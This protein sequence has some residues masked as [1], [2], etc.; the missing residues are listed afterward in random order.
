MS[1]I[2]GRGLENASVRKITVDW[3]NDICVEYKN[4]TYVTFVVNVGLHVFGCTVGS[5]IG[6]FPG[7]PCCFS[8]CQSLPLNHCI[9]GVDRTS[10]QLETRCGNGRLWGGGI[11]RTV[12]DRPKVDGGAA[13]P[14]LFPCARM[15]AHHCFVSIRPLKSLAEFERRFGPASQ[16]SERGEIYPA[17]HN[18]LSRTCCLV[19]R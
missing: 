19:G 14:A 11:E 18:S 9:R 4:F 12:R 17:P 1:K 13:H 3:E 2:R 10:H 8:N 7:P 5:G 6:V 16:S 15:L